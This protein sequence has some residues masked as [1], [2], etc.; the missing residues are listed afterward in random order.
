[1]FRG[2][3]EGLL[4]L[5]LLGKEN[6]LMFLR[7]YKILKIIFF[8]GDLNEVVGVCFLKFGRS[9]RV[10]KLVFNN[11]DRFGEVFLNVG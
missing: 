3:F 7:S 8:E 10:L 4:W 11:I 5:R 6:T 9:C 1:M 2:F